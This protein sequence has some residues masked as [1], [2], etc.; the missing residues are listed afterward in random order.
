MSAPVSRFNKLSL[1]RM[2]PQT[3]SQARME[4]TRSSPETDPDDSSSDTGS[5]SDS[6]EFDS[7]SPVVR[8]PAR[9]TYVV[10]H[11]PERTQTA[12]RD[13]FS[14]P[15]KIALQK[16]RLIND[17]YA[18][19]MTETVTRSVR[20]R[21]TECGP[22]RFSCSCS[23]DSEPCEHRLWLLDQILQ[24]TLYEHD[25]SKPLTMSPQGFAEELGDPFQS[26]ARHHLDVLADGIHCQLVTPDSEYDDEIDGHRL[27]E[28]RELLASVF[29][30]TPEDYRPDLFSR[31]TMGK[32]V[33]KRD[34][35]DQTVLRMLLHNHSFFHYFR[36]ISRPTDPINDPFRKLSQ[37]IDRV[38]RDLDEYA[39]G[40]GSESS[41]E[42]PPDVS[43][44]AMHILGCV[45]LI[46]AKIY[47]RDRPLTPPEAISAARCLVHLLNAVVS[48]NRDAHAGA[49][50]VER[51]LYL[52]LVGDRDQGFVIDVLNLIP[53]A[54]SQFLNSLEEVLEKL[55]VHGA[56]ASYVENFRSLL[57][58]LRKS[59]RGSGVKRQVQGQGTDRG[60]KRMK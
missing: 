39:S 14:E 1:S 50:R 31:P 24:Q 29:D 52:R 9:L 37:R 33:L 49:S 8:S 60:S 19:Q 11:L 46:R 4:P 5:E 32:K 53:E 28:S 16:C 22:P 54:A 55:G 2:P 36:T 42:T 10:D 57:G 21:A 3:R 30:E 13:A 45:R 25:T 40:S 6:S 38:L 23:E 59:G 34:D 27:Q 48:R 51:N 17:T 43:W 41:I 47:T 12:V 56:P 18:F 20:I 15:P 26:I 35:L 7:D 58:R 44:A